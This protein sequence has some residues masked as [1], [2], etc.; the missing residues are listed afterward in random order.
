[1][2]FFLDERQGVWAAA[3][4]VTYVAMVACSSCACRDGCVALLFAAAWGQIRYSEYSENRDGNAGVS[5]GVGGGCCSFC[6]CTASAAAMAPTAASY[7]S[8]EYNKKHRHA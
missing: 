6:N 3:S 2:R 8:N 5:V 4:A 7:S 1:M